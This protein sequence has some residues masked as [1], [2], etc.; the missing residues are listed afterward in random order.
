MRKDADQAA[1]ATPSLLPGEPYFKARNGQSL[2]YS[3]DLLPGQVVRAS[4]AE[5]GEIWV[6]LESLRTPVLTVTPEEQAQADRLESG[7]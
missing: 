4:Y 3:Y 2:D 7:S 5:R 6:R 1:G